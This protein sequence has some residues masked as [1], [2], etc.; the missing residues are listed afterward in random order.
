MGIVRFGTLLYEYTGAQ[1]YRSMAAQ[2]MRYLAAPDVATRL[3]V[4]GLLLADDELGSSPLHVAVVG[5]REDEGTRA[6]LRTALA[7]P[8][9]YK[10][11]EV[12]DPRD[13]AQPRNDIQYPASSRPAAYVCSEGRCSFP[14]RTPVALRER[15]DRLAST[16]EAKAP[17]PPNP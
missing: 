13:G 9:S 14:S 10:R 3:E 1:K 11:V 17:P 6:L 16:N 2:A 4:A 5:P 12:V 15:L 8:L 7:F